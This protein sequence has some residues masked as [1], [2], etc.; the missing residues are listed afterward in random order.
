MPEPST[1]DLSQQIDLVLSWGWTFEG[2][3]QKNG[4]TTATYAPPTP[5][6][7]EAEAVDTGVDDRQV[8]G[9]RVVHRAPYADMDGTSD[10]LTPCCSRPWQGLVVSHLGQYVTCTGP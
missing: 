10:G 8:L 9:E 4:W 1:P 6:R 2:S 3:V 5:S 7:A